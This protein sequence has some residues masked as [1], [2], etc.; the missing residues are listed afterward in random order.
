MAA[1]MKSAIMEDIIMEGVGA[2]MEHTAIR[3]NMNLFASWGSTIYHVQYLYS[4]YCPQR[5]VY[6][7]QYIIYCILNSSICLL[8]KPPALIEKQQQQQQQQRQQQQDKQVA[9]T[10]RAQWWTR[11]VQLVAEQ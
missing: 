7:I 11:A 9:R 2:P 8:I 5:C 4:S 3:K 10:A 1:I 6:S